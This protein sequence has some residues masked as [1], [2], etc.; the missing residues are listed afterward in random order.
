MTAN[1]SS[2][3]DRA[4]RIIKAAVGFLSYVQK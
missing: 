1:P 4:S 3:T 2:K